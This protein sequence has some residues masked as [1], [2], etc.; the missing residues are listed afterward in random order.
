[1]FIADA[2][3]AERY[4]RRVMGFQQEEFWV[5]ALASN[6]NLIGGK[7]IFLGTVDMCLIH[8]RDIFRYALLTNA[9]QLMIAHNHP[10]GDSAPSMEDI[11]VTNRLVRSGQLLGIPIIEHL[12]LTEE[13]CFSF[14]RHQ[15]I[16]KR[17][18]E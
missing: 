3:S 16:Q 17:D 4:L 11:K 12:I 14:R 5:I 8:P 6:L 13:D 1:M 2:Q 10:S 18:L 9:S 7:M 15:L